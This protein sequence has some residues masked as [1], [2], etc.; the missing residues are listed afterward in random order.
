[1]KMIAITKEIKNKMSICV[2]NGSGKAT[3]QICHVKIE[4]GINNQVT[5]QGFRSSQCCHR[6]CIIDWENI[7][8]LEKIENEE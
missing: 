7:K 2:K 6:S 4:K 5:F 8:L 3:C 1:M